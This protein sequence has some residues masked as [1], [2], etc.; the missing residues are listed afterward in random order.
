MQMFLN[1]LH[2]CVQNI[3]HIF[4]QEVDFSS[5]PFSLSPVRIAATDHTV[6][7]WT[8]SIKMVGGLTGLKIDPWGFLLPLRL[9]VWV[10]TLTALLIVLAVQ[11]LFGS[12]LPDGTLRLGGWSANTFSGV[13]IILQQGEAS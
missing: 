2:Y 11:Q 3:I 1:L 13:R 8:G 9:L 10:A 4:F 6:P 12:C 5:G 7:L